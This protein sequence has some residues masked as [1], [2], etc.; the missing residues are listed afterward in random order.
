MIHLIM[1]RVTPDELH[2]MLQVLVIS[3]SLRWMSNAEFWRAAARY[4]PIVKPFAVWRR[5]WQSIWNN[6]E[7]RQRVATQAGKWSARVLELS[8][9][10]D[11][12]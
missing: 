7:Q 1:A 8:G 12:N 4:T 3:S 5:K 9:L 2:D 11:E 10:L 6:I